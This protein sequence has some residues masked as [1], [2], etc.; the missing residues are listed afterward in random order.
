MNQ[1]HDI[2]ENGELSAEE[3]NKDIRIMFAQDLSLKEK[4]GSGPDSFLIDTEKKDPFA[5]HRTREQQDAEDG[6]H[7]FMFQH[8]KLN[9]NLIKIINCLGL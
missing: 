6:G 4:I 1:I 2:L 5:D 3:K 8:L 9:V 7:V